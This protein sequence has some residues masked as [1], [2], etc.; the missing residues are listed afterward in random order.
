MKV[1]LF[2]KRLVKTTL[3][4]LFM[5]ISTVA[6]VIAFIDFH[7]A[8]KLSVLGFIILLSIP[9]HLILLRRANKLNS[10]TLKI[11]NSN[12][13]IEFGDIFNEEDN[14][15]IPFNEYFDTSFENNLISDTSLHGQYL[16]T[17]KSTETLDSEIDNIP[18]EKMV[19][20][21]SDKKFGKKKKYKPGTI[22]QR[23]KYFLLAFSHFDD[24]NR[25]YLTQNEYV[26]CLL[27]MWAEIDKIY[28]GK[29]VC[30]PLLGSGI[31]RFVDNK[32]ISDQELLSIMIWTF[33]ISKVKFTWPSKVKIIIYTEKSDKINL[34]KV[35]EAK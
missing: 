32:D 30:M 10:I 16:K 6:S 34:F 29:T 35:K 4:I 28:N 20:V 11:N 23:T 26:E 21:K 3:E 7:W 19:E 13:I 17:L 8:V 15:I 9:L 31:T 25:A 18:V 33:R 5:A 2:D 14:K 27:N 1:T 24:D 22:L 12:L